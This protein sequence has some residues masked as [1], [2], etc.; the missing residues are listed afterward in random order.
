MGSLLIRNGLL[1]TMNATREVYEGNL[2]CEDGLIR[3]VASQ[4]SEADTVIEAQGRMVL[5]GFI[6][7]HVHL[8][9]TL[10]RG[11]ADDMDVI[12]W[13]RRRIW[14]LE[15]SH[16]E[17][18]LYSSAL[19][20]IVEMIKSGTTTALTMETVNHTDAVFQAILES[21]FRAHSGKAMMDVVELGTGMVGESTADSLA[22][23]KR[24]LF[25]FHEKGNGRLRYALCP[26][27]PGNTSTEL[28]AAVARLA[29]EHMIIIHTH[30]AESRA[31][32]EKWS[33][34]PRGS[35][36]VYLH[37]LGLTG[38]NLVLAHCIWVTDEEKWIIKETGT[39]V[40]HCPSSNLK[41]ASG[42]A[43]IPEMLEMGINVSLGADGAPCNNNLDIF[44][45]MRLASLI[46]KPRLGPRTMPAGQVL[47]MATIGGARALG[48]E[49]QIGSL[50]VGKRADIVLLN[51]QVPHANPTRGSEPS[52][53]LVYAHRGHDVDTVIIDGQVLLRKGQFTSLDE[54]R[55]L[56]EAERALER[57]LSRVGSMA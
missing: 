13:L 4:C 21:G 31:L 56:A 36:V 10:F 27:G 7:T 18:S 20:S 55:V 22:E 50:E 8:C 26:R 37:S 2:Y 42:I 1:V 3:E 30:A 54:R 9:Q 25:A 14:P 49:D 52:S 57:L 39:N 32:T 46:Q 34:S 35:D 17:E 51:R 38:K 29:K 11:L 23:T 24:L 15:S 47:E 16:N 6:Q 43:P 12:N 53:A 45:E 19:L 40:S 33:S 44:Q 41:L 48:M 28:L 5:P